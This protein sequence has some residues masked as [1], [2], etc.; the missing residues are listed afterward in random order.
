MDVMKSIFRLLICFFSLLNSIEL[1]SQTEKVIETPF[2][3]GEW[4]EF[5]IYYGFFNA[6]YA[7]IK[8]ENDTINNIPVLHS[9]G[10]GKTTGLARWF[11]KVD[12]YYESYFDREKIIPYKFIRNIYEGGYTKNIEINFNQ[13]KLI[14]TINDKKKNTITKLPF[15]YNAQDLVSSFYYL[16]KYFPRDKFKINES[17]VINMFFD[18]DNYVF[19]LKY[20][21]NEV[22]DS[23]FGK[24]E[25][26][27]FIPMV[28]SGRIFKE[29]ESVTIWISNDKNRI[30]IRVQADVIVGSIKADLDNFKNLKYPF[31]IKF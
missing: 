2:D 16:R 10:Y 1:K 20:L 4:F 13:E 9:M 24:I 7:S 26:L 31:K 6:S 28:Q 8:L 15:N 23:K 19:K 25:C 18:N 29:Q 3:G 14:A 27:K 30:P 17:F 11:F 12:D 22:I 5:R 21:G